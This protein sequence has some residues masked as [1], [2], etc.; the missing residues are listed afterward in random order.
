MK[1]SAMESK[2]NSFGMLNKPVLKDHSVLCKKEVYSLMRKTSYQLLQPILN[3][4]SLKMCRTYT[5][6]LNWLIRGRKHTKTISCVNKRNSH[7]IVRK[8][9][10][11]SLKSRM[12]ATSKTLNTPLLSRE[13]M[14]TSSLVAVKPASLTQWK[15]QKHKQ[16]NQACL[17]TTNPTL[18]ALLNFKSREERRT[19]KIWKHSNQI[20]EC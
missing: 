12:K 8:S 15:T 17:G 20:L 1:P 9:R 5:Q 7:S 10:L 3:T 14:T 19:S 13:S 2:T 4:R 16:V 6:L 18:K 11:S